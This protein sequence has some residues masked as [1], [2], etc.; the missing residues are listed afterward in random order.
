MSKKH[1]IVAVT[2]IISMRTA[3][4]QL[5]AETDLEAVFR[6]LEEKH[7]CPRSSFDSTTDSV[8]K[9][10]FICAVLDKPLVLHCV[11]CRDFSDKVRGGKK[12]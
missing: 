7:N 1:F 4:Y 2:P 10:S 11:E 8:E 6:V 12:K 5:M 3:I 9:V